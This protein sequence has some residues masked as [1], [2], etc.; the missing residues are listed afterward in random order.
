MNE[1]DQMQ[2]HL[3]NTYFTMSSRSTLVPYFCRLLFVINAQMFTGSLYNSKSRT[4][5]KKCNYL[6][7]Y[8]TSYFTNAKY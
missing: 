7:E 6:C 4:A 5:V 3:S 2:M 1:T 8:I